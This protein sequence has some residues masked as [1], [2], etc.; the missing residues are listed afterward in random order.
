MYALGFHSQQ[1]KLLSPLLSDFDIEIVVIY[2]SL[3]PFILYTFRRIKF[4]FERFQVPMNLSSLY[5][6]K[7]M[8]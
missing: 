7:A 5:F 4:S 1:D 8:K 6:M 2:S 3:S